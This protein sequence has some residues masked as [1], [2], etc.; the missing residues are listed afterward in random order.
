MSADIAELSSDTEKEFVLIAHWLVDVPCKPGAL[1]GLKS[2]VG[3]RDFGDW[4]EEEYDG[5]QENEGGDTEVGP[6]H[7]GEVVGVRGLEEHTRSQKG[8]HDRADGLEGLR[9]F[10]TELG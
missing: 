9:E 5:Q 8:G 10:K 3:I 1:F 6:L 7:V 2:H 4:R